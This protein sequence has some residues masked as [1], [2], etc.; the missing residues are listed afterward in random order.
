MRTVVPI[1]KT[2][3]N[4]CLRET[5]GDTGAVFALLKFFATLSGAEK[6]TVS[7]VR[8]TAADPDGTGL[9]GRRKIKMPT[10]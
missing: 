3:R 10:V 8:P 7:Q 2:T 9:D 5:P 4:L 6:K 1:N